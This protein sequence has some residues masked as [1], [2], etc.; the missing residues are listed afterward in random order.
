MKRRPGIAAAA[1]A[2]FAVLW[3]PTAAAADSA[4]GLHVDPARSRASF[5]VSHVLLDHVTGTIPIVSGT[6]VAAA[7]GSPSRVS[8]TLDPKGIDTTNSDRDGDLQSGAWFDTADYPAIAFASTRIVRSGANSFSIEGDL[9]I[10]GVTR[11]VT[12]SC[13]L[14]GSQP[15]RMGPPFHYVAQTQIK[16]DDFMPGEPWANVLIG[17]TVSI[18]LDIWTSAA[19]PW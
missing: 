14:V 7:D 5:T 18:G 11:A 13:T 9:T 6:I 3:L 19:P 10:R 12:L 1:F 4:A 8:A 17:R 15:I 16:R 2:T